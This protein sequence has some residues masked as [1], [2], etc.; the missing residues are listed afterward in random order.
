MRLQM[1]NHSQL[2]RRPAI[3]TW[4]QKTAAGTAK[5]AA[6]DICNNGLNVMVV[7]NTGTTGAVYTSTDGIATALTQISAGTGHPLNGKYLSVTLAEDLS[8]I[9]IY[10][11][12][13]EYTT[14][15]STWLGLVNSGT[16]T[17]SDAALRKVGGFASAHITNATAAKYVRTDMGSAGKTHGLTDARGVTMNDA[18]TKVIVC[19][20]GSGC[21]YTTDFN[22]GTPTFTASAGIAG[23]ITGVQTNYDGSLAMATK[24]G[25]D[26]YD[27]TDS[28]ANFAVQSAWGTNTWQG[29]RISRDGTIRIAWTFSQIFRSID[30]GVTVTDISLPGG[31][32]VINCG[33]SSDG[34]KVIS[35]TY[36]GYIYIRG[37]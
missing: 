20:Y 19:S 36:D 3:A 16:V 12:S 32:G 13:A 33:M 34:S 30:S 26:V 10:P 25:G 23:N 17:A 15:G 29:C 22:V 2:W 6:F 5:W 35:G 1:P 28:G 37:F 24:D 31:V 4:V 8:A 21:K 7:S 18:K 27:S 14:N 9:A 11:T